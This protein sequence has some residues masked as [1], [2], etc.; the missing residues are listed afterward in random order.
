MDAQQ[1]HEK[2]YATGYMKVAD[3]KWEGKSL[4]ITIESDNVSDLIE[5]PARRLAYDTRVEHGLAN[6]GIES[7]GGTYVPEEELRQAKQLGRN[8]AVWRADFRITPLRG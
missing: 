7:L 5:G 6:A 8:V 2:Y 4:I 3:I 1:L